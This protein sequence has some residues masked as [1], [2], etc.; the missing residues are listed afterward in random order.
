METTDS[1]TYLAPEWTTWYAEDW[2]TLSLDQDTPII[3]EWDMLDF[4]L[5][6]KA[7][8]QWNSTV[9]ID[10]WYEWW[11]VAFKVDDLL[12]EN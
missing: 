4:I 3:F 6:K 8:N 5:E 2:N 11:Y 9:D 10:I 7:A 12:T 1:R